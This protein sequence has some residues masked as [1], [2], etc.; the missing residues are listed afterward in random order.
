MVSF[1]EVNSDS[2]DENKISK[3]IEKLVLALDS[4]LR[5]VESIQETKLKDRLSI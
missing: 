2:D 5:K 4:E 1:E 3:K